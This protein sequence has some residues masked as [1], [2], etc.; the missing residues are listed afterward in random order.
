MPNFVYL[1]NA[2]TTVPT[3]P[4]VIRFMCDFYQTK[5]VFFRERGLRKQPKPGAWA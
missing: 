3:P 1:D 5:G 2:A 4:E